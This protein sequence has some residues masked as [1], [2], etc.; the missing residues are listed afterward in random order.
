M[1]V[2]LSCVI[3]AAGRGTRLKLSTPKALL[4]I[5]G[6]RMVDY[7]IGACSKFFEKLIFPRPAINEMSL[8]ALLEKLVTHIFYI[9]CNYTVISFQPLTNLAVANN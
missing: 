9:V 8:L 1:I 3:L 4:T 5:A 2:D 6:T 7:A